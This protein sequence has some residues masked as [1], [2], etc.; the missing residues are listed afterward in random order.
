MARPKKLAPLAT[1]SEP[2][3]SIVSPIT[4]VA[5][6][7]HVFQTLEQEGA[8]P[9]L[10]SIGYARISPQSRSFVSYVIT[11]RGNEVLKMEVS[12]PNLMGIAAEQSKIDFV[13]QFVDNEGL[14][15]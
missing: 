8:L 15:P 1:A 9:I 10:K 12:E 14:L 5:G 4:T 6:E 2:S 13:T 11:S 7:S 3:P